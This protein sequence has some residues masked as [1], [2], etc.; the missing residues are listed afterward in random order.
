MKKFA[1]RVKAPQRQAIGQ[2]ITRL[3]PVKGWN[4]RDPIAGMDPAYALVLE[5]FFPVASGVS[6]RT[7]ASDWV[8]GLT[9]IVK[10]LMSY[11]GP[12][13]SKLFGITDTKIFDATASATNP[14]LLLART[15]GDHVYTNFTG[16]GGSYLF[17]VN[18][19]DSLAQYDGTTWS[20]VASYPITGGGTLNT[21]TLAVV[22]VFKRMLFF[23][24]NSGT[25]FYFLPIDQI[26]GTVSKFPLGG[27]MSKGGYI[28][29]VGTWSVGADAGQDDYCV[30]I[31]SRGQMIVYKGTDP[32]NA[33]T[34]ALQGIY[35]V[36]PPLGRNCLYKQHGDL[37]VLTEGGLFSMN[38]AFGS[39]A[40]SLRADF[41]DNIGPTFRDFAALTG[42]VIGWQV[43]VFELQRMLFI[44]VPQQALGVFNQFVMNLDTGAWCRFIGWDAY[45]FAILDSTLY[46]AA[47]GKVCK[48]LQSGGDF[49]GT[50]TANAAQ[51]FDFL[52]PRATQKSVSLFR[53]VNLL[54]GVGTL[55]TGLDADYSSTGLYENPTSPIG[56][57]AV[58]DT[59]VWDT[60]S[61]AG[62]ALPNLAWQTASVVEGF[63]FSVRLRF[64]GKD[65]TFQWTETDYLYQPGS[66][67]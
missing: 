43:H 15:K 59:A 54:S 45:N 61:F 17:A 31:T 35:N 52:S 11:Q 39:T 65:A 67:L 27:L 7:G 30:F 29:A 25:S 38:T 62:S 14:A 60:S 33:A 46:F 55:W 21:N 57:S 28:A 34:W 20:A 19:A 63:C 22:S 26:S 9:G 5:N 6:L 18:G 56:G 10:T 42:S 3:P 47:N 50:I 37:Y 12:S 41:T 51:A 48:A 8:V 64:I 16:T 1:Q 44:N 66:P 13:T 4:T 32:S 58:W 40:S 2:T 53:P 24:E 36:S 23:I 49:G